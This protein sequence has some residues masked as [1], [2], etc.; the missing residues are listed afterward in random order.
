MFL[1]IQGEI[2]IRILLNYNKLTLIIEFN[3]KIFIN[4]YD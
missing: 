3:V 1:L 4:L 2:I